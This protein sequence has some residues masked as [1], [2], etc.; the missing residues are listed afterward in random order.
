[1]RMLIRLV[2]ATES[3]LKT[4]GAQNIRAKSRFQRGNLARLKFLEVQERPKKPSLPLNRLP[5]RT[6]RLIKPYTLTILAYLPGRACQTMEMKKTR[7]KSLLWVMRS[8]SKTEFRRFF[9]PNRLKFYKSR[10]YYPFHE[11][12]SLIETEKEICYF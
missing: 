1:M 10:L 3:M 4:A 6:N 2:L 8:S 7:M 9:P 5:S 12:P 11:A